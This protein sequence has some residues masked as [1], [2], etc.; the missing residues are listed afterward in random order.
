MTR[1]TSH[2][3][4]MKCF[5]II[6]QKLKENTSSLS[7]AYSKNVDGEMRKLLLSFLKNN[8][9]EKNENIFLSYEYIK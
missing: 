1:F 5:T 4:T 8:F 2:S 3:Q 6:M 9:N 7:T